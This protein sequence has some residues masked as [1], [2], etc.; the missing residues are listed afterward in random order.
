MECN[1]NTFEPSVSFAALTDNLI[2][3]I[4]SQSK[5]VLSDKYIDALNV[6][7][8][9]DADDFIGVLGRLEN[10]S[11]VLQQRVALI[12]K[13]QGCHGEGGS[14]TTNQVLQAL[15]TFNEFVNADLVAVHKDLFSPYI[16][17]TK[18]SYVAKDRYISS[19]KRF[20]ERAMYILESVAMEMGNVT[21]VYEEDDFDVYL[22]SLQYL[23]AFR[24]YKDLLLNL[25]SLSKGG[26]WNSSDETAK[27]ELPLTLFNSSDERHSCLEQLNRVLSI[28]ENITQYLSPDSNFYSSEFHYEDLARVTE[29]DNACFGSYFINADEQIKKMQTRIDGQNSTISADLSNTLFNDGVREVVMSVIQVLHDVK[30]YANRYRLGTVSMFQ[31]PT[32]KATVTLALHVF[33]TFSCHTQGTKLAGSRVSQMKIWLNVVK[34]C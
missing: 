5:G 19:R 31:V 15:Q 27:V 34:C 18:Q 6:A 16:I 7:V 32:A 12:C 22:T 3:Q 30:E 4:L 8:R 28:L 29:I 17:A 14:S 24:R 2:I 23:R 11:D 33:I 1:R 10:I 20:K 9:V 26:L 25:E 21:S 13:L